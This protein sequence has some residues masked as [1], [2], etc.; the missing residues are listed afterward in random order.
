MW[1]SEA[2]SAAGPFLVGG[3]T[4]AGVWFV[5]RLVLRFQRDFTDRYSLELSAERGRREQAEALIDRLRREHAEVI[6]RMRAEQDALRHRL[7]T[8]TAALRTAG[9]EVPDET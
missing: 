8:V 4:L 2:G 1:L 3:S 6:D 5:V 7:D 9:I